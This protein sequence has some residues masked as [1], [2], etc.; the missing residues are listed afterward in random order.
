MREAFDRYD[1]DGSGYLDRDEFKIAWRMIYNKRTFEELIMF[2]KGSYPVRKS[3]GPND[4]R[5]SKMI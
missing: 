2:S 1:L 4:R 3:Q 5:A